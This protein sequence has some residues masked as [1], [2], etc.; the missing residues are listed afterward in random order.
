MKLVWS[1]VTALLGGLFLFS[2]GSDVWEAY[3]ALFLA[4]LGTQ[5]IVMWWMGRGAR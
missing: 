5:I 3:L 2:L 1:V 4:S